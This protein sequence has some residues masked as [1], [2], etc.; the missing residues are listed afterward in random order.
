MKCRNCKIDL[1]DALGSECEACYRE[2]LHS[3]V[4]PPKKGVHPEVQKIW[5]RA[6][7]KHFTPQQVQEFVNKTVE[8]VKTRGLIAYSEINYW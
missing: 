7:P 8:E 3:F 2:R 1:G 5:N 6:K 4:H